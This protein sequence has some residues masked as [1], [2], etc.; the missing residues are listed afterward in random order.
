MANACLKDG[1]GDADQLLHLLRLGYLRDLFT[2]LSAHP[3][4]RLDDLLPDRCAQSAF[5]P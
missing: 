2:R 1:R 3:H 5:Q 4:F